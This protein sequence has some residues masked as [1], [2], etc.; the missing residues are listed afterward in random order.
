MPMIFFNYLQSLS[1][2]EKQFEH[3][4]VNPFCIFKPIH[5]CVW[6]YV[7]SLFKKW[8]NMGIDTHLN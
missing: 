2:Q 7:L 1:L 5:T 8:E 3:F 4:I 6:M